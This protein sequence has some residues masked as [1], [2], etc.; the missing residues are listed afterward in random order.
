MAV[1]FHLRDGDLLVDT[2]WLVN[3]CE[4]GSDEHRTP[5][6]PSNLPA[7]RNSRAVPQLYS[8]M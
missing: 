6:E 8:P 4:S 5:G 2:W 3:Y 7:G 1:C